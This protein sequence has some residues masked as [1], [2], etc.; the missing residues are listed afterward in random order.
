MYTEAKLPGHGRPKELIS[1]GLRLNTYWGKKTVSEI[2][3]APCEEYADFSSTKSMARRDLEMLRAAVGHYKKRVGLDVTPTFTLPEKELPRT[4]W[5]TRSEAAKL[6]WTAYRAG[7][8]HLVRFILIGIYTGTRSGAILDL[9][10]CPNLIGGFINL[11]AGVMYREPPGSRKTNKRKPPCAIPNRLMPHLRRWAKQ[12]EGLLYVIHWKGEHINRIYKAFV[13]CVSAAGLDN[14]VIPHCLRDTA[15][16]WA[17][18][19]GLKLTSAS[20]ALGMTVKTLE[21]NYW[22]HHPD[23]QQ[24]LRELY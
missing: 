5:L 1:M 24:D 2:V 11:E 22:H 20:K 7:N 8:Q 16:T 10:W 12:D 15:A 21:E 3:G 9:Q 19:R 14:K 4:R 17:M 18:Q 23:Y 13:T 6:L